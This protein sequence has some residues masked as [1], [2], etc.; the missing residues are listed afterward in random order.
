MKYVILAGIYLTPLV[1]LNYL[2][3]PELAKLQEFYS[4]MDVYVHKAVH[5]DLQ[6]ADQ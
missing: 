1:L 3:L 2:V 6:S 4:N 5:D